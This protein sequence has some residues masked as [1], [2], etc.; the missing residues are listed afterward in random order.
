VL[1]AL[2]GQAAFE[3]TV[4][5]ALA[6]IPMYVLPAALRRLYAPRATPTREAGTPDRRDGIRTP[7]TRRPEVS[8][9]KSGCRDASA[10]PSAGSRS[11][12]RW[13]TCLASGWPSCSRIV[14]ASCHAPRAAW[15]SPAACQVSPRWIST[16]LSSY[17]SPRS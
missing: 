11:A 8:P 16:M 6:Q 3:V 9:R 7:A 12:S 14:N 10:Q 15:P 13:T 17:L 1:V 5:F 4:F 2:Q